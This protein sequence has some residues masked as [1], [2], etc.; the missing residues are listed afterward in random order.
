MLDAFD[1]IKF[2]ITYEYDDKINPFYQMNYLSDPVIYCSR[3]NVISSQVNDKA[4]S[5]REFAY[6][7]QG[8]QLKTDVY[9]GSVLTYES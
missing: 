6:N 7:E 5:R 3:N 2:T 1:N 9:G 8:L 4:P